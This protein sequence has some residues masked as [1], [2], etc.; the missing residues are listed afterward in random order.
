MSENNIQYIQIIG[1]QRSGSNLLRVMLNQFSEIAAPHPPHI[2]QKF[3]PF[4]DHYG[5]L[6]IDSNYMQL[7]EDICKYIEINPVPWGD[8]KFNPQQIF[9]ASKTRS[10]YEV[11]RLVY[12]AY[13]KANDASIWCCKSMAIINFANEL[14]ENNLKPFYIYL[15]RDGRDVACSFKKA[16][17][18]EKHIYNI[19]RKWNKDQQLSLDLISTLDESRYYKL[20]YEQL[21][22]EPEKHIKLICN[23]L[24][25]GFNPGILDYYN[26]EESRNTAVAGE[27]WLNV[28]KP[29]IKNNTKK[30]KSGLTKHEILIFESE[31]K[32][33]LNQLGYKTDYIVNGNRMHFSQAEISQFN[34]ENE[35]QKKLARFN[36]LKSDLVKRKPQEMFIKS[37]IERNEI[38]FF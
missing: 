27:M 11:F 26:S 12:E 34:S 8:S 1:T 10:I 15:Y 16:I 21:I 4:L 2:L 33:T 23:K 37:I 6:N 17:V 7:V 24:G 29:I 19:A 25:I 32:D 13:A 31:T 9:T 18:G 20:S 30:Y 28:K 14:E 5:D 3:I 22:A 35:H 36:A 38:L